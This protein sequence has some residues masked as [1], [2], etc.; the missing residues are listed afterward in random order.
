MSFFIERLKKMKKVLSI[1]LVL[2][3]GIGLYFGLKNIDPVEVVEEVSKVELEATYFEYGTGSKTV[4]VVVVVEE[5]LHII[6][7]LHTDANNLEEALK[8]VEKEIELV[9]D[10]YINDIYI[11]GF[12]GREANEDSKEYY[13]FYVNDKYAATGPGGEE[14]DDGDVY[15]FSLKNW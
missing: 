4:E 9:Y 1:I 8:E 10:Q 5:E 7:T 13:A 14:I 12:F 3:V 11:K 2:V 6:T 15:R